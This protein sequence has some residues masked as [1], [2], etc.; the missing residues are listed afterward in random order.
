MLTLM[1]SWH[2]SRRQSRESTSEHTWRNTRLPSY[3]V[4]NS[5]PSMHNVPISQVRRRFEIVPAL[6]PVC[7]V[8]KPT[9]EADTDLFFVIKPHPDVPP[10]VSTSPSRVSMSPSPV[11]MSPSP[12]SMS[13]S[14]V[15]TS[16]SRVSSSPF[17]VSMSPS[18][19][20]S[21]SPSLV[22]RTL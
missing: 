12:V 13:P 21:V 7:S 14:S 3:R 2:V 4:L 9:P 11:S 10:R 22:V 16:P 8:L 6:T 18:S 20:I 1:Q 5:S 19:G 17:P 15:S